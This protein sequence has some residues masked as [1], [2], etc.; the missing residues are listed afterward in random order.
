MREYPIPEVNGVQTAIDSLGH[1]NA[2]N[3]KPAAVMDT[4]VIE[5]VRKTGFIDKLYGRPPKN[6]R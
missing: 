3:I 5:E 2:R 1:P 4:S 6:E